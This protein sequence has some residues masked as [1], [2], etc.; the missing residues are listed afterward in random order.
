MTAKEEK[1]KD[2]R[3]NERKKHSQTEGVTLEDETAHV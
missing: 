2:K 1:T 3:K